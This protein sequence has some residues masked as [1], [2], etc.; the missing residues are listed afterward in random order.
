MKEIIKVEN[1]DGI[2]VTTSNRVADELKVLHKDLLE[3]IDKYVS[4]FSS[5]EIS[6][7]FYIPSNYVSSNGRTVRNYLI[8]EKGVA[9]LLGGY[10]SAVEKAFELNV[11]YINEFER[12][13]KYILS[14][15]QNPYINMSPQELMI[16][17][18]KEQEKMKKEF[19]N[20]FDELEEKIDNKIT[21]NSYQQRRIQRLTSERVRERIKAR[22]E[23]K[24]HEKLLFGAIYRRIKDTFGIPSYKDLLEKDI[25]DCFIVINSFIEDKY[26]LEGRD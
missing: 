13:K 6:A 25:D 12:M 2:L 14:Q 5:A 15:Q 17:T 11:A 1:I 26:I 16:E 9:Q 19:N 7:E 23:L 8:A 20:K 22:P 3:K 4:K 18:L 10:S 24:G 21:I